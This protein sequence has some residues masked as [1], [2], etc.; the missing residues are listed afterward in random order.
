MKKTLFLLLLALCL[1]SAM[2][3]QNTSGNCYRGFVDLGYNM[4]I[5]N[6]EIGRF[7]INIDTSHGYQINPFIY[8]GVGAGL[9]Y[10]HEYKT[11]GM[12]IPLDSR[13]STIDIP[14]FANVRFN[15]GKGKMV[16]FVDGKYGKF[17]TNNG[18]KY[19]N[20]SAGLRIA[21]NE[22]QAINFA[23]GYTREELEFETFDDFYDSNSMAYR[24]CPRKLMTEGI[25]FKVEC[26]F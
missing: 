1:S 24:T 19:M 22:K 9:H 2:K 6:Y 11:F 25:T 16:P 17:M 23:V 8:L 7:G 4:A 14:V 21:A 20:L 5:G 15:M 3:A 10:I 26:E 13:E 18:G 12:K